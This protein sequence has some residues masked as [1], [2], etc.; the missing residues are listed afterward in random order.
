[1]LPAQLRPAQW[2]ERRHSAWEALSGAFRP[3]RQPEA[4]RPGG[5]M[6][7]LAAWLAR[8]SSCPPQGASSAVCR[9]A[10]AVPSSGFRR[11]AWLPVATRVAF[12]EQ[13][14]WPAPAVAWRPLAA[15]VSPVQEVVPPSEPRA[16]EAESVKAAA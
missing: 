6:E 10:A 3:V 16:A 2:Q 8:S 4:A 9:R 14:S 7:W 5:L 13:A 1:L 15:G 12:A 11:A